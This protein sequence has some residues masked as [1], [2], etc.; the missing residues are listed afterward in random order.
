MLIGMLQLGFVASN[1]IETD[2]VELISNE[3]DRSG[4][5]QN[6]RKQYIQAEYRQKTRHS[7]LTFL[8]W[9]RNNRN[10]TVELLQVKP[11]RRKESCPTQNSIVPSVMVKISLGRTA[12][13]QNGRKAAERRRKAQ[14]G[15]LTVLPRSIPLL[16]ESLGADLNRWLRTWLCCVGRSAPR[17][18][19]QAVPRR[20]GPCIYQYGRICRF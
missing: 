2:F 8:A 20:V 1:N 16:V 5:A 17:R 3:P 10:R 6:G 11:N 9:S 13:T 12:E 14:K 7:D 15:T 19:W 4:T 18:S